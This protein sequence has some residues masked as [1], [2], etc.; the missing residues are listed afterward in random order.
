MHDCPL[1]NY[2]N[3]H[4]VIRLQASKANIEELVNKFQTIN[5]LLEFKDLGGV[6]HVSVD[7]MDQLKIDEHH[8]RAKIN[9]L[10][11]QIQLSILHLFDRGLVSLYG[12]A[13][14]A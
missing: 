10:P 9:D 6:L 2:W 1:L 4:Q 7:D 11:L 8:L 5:P 13:H 14:Q 12:E 3:T